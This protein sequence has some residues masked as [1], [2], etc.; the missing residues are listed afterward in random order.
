MSNYGKGDWQTKWDG[1]FWRFMNL[2]RD[3]FL[4]NPRL[5]MLI[6]IFDKM[7]LSKRQKHIDVANAF[8]EQL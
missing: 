3:Y 6:R 2:H 5:G 4:S 1:L 8:L 7:P